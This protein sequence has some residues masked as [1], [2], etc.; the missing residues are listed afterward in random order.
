M[1]QGPAKKRPNYQ[2]IETTESPVVE[3]PTVSLRGMLIHNVTRVQAVDHIISCAE[4]GVGG[5]VVTPNLDILRRHKNCP[6]FR[7]LLATSSLNVADGMPLVWA[8]RIKGDPLVERVNGTDLMVDV[9]E[10]AAKS[11]HTTFFLGG[12]PGTA[13]KTAMNIQDSFPGI[14]ISGCLCPEFGFESSIDSI[15][16]IAEQ[17]TACKPDIVFVGLG[18]PKQDVLINALRLQ[19]PNTWWLGVGVSFSF[20]GDELAR[21]PEWAKKS[22]F[23]WLYRLVTEPKRLAKRYLVDGIPFF[24]TTILISAYQRVFGP[25]QEQSDSVEQIAGAESS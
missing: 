13:E 1:A 20:L 5:W 19:F 6:A 14:K 7:N 9:C 11:G 16:E 18:S 21:A 2:R 24:A 23:E 22:G 10:A 12:N 25:K 8:S 17:L 3:F 4:K 15:R